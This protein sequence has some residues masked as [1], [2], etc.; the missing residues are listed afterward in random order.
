[1]PMIAKIEKNLD[2]VLVISRQMFFLNA[3]FDVF[4]INCLLH[5][6]CP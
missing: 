4:L 1:M 3:F 6:L 2:L 5:R